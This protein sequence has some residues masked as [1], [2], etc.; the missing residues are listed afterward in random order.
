LIMYVYTYTRFSIK[1]QMHSRKAIKDY[2][3]EIPGSIVK[4]VD[5]ID[6]KIKYTH[7]FAFPTLYKETSRGN[8]M[9][10]HIL[11]RVSSK[12]DNLNPK[13]FYTSDPPAGAKAYYW[14][15][16][17]E[18]TESG[19]TPQVSAP[20]LIASGKNIDKAN[21]TN[22][23]TQALSEAFNLFREKIKNKYRTDLK[24]KDPNPWRKPPARFELLTKNEKKVKFPAYILP[25]LDGV[26][27]ETVLNPDGQIEMISRQLL[28]FLNTPKHIKALKP[29]FKKFPNIMLFGEFYQH[30]LKLQ[31]IMSVCT[32]N[33][34]TN[35]LT[36][37]VFDC[38]LTDQLDM[39]YIQRRALLKKIFDTLIEE[40]D[41]VIR[42]KSP[43][44]NNK[45]EL[46]EKYNSYLD[47][48][49][50]GGMLYLE[51]GDYKF[52]YTASRSKS[53]FKMKPRRSD[54]FKIIGFKD[55]NGK[56]KGLVTFIMETKN[57]NK[58]NA[59]PNMP[60]D[61]RRKLFNEFQKKFH[62]KG[63]MG[64]VT[65]S[66]LSEKGIPL[67]PKFIAVVDENL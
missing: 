46:N 56:N 36:Y 32:N 64:T 45:E 10:W 15:W 30:G 40:N 33:D 14:T 49:Y 7:V 63:K 19:G 3:K 58:F 65:Y 48:G 17:V 23:F 44:V 1:K 22:V 18:N 47:K 11:V 38:I 59:E 55:G 12:N 27:C 62:Y 42:M 25:K 28:P 54:E 9:E 16:T 24:S 50:E 37:F 35:T 8:V 51:D 13:D 39:P 60:E 20:T 67:Q 5:P 29:V 31:Q 57:K 2:K 6:P 66:D 26:F 21:E 34:N 41:Y 53:V 4:Y 52:Y 61:E 43:K